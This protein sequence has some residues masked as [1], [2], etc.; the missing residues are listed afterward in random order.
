MPTSF[1]Q[2]LTDRIHEVDSLLC[3]GL[4]PHPHLLPEH[5]PQA[6]RDFCLRLIESTAKA[7]C[8]FKPNSA[9]FEVLGS[10]GMEVLKEVIEAVPNGIPVILDAKRGDIAS[11]SRYYAR[12]AFHMLGADALTVSP[13]LGRDSIDPMIEDPSR[14]AFLLCK[15]SNPGGED[16]QSRVLAGGDPLYLHLARQAVEWNQSDNLGLVVGA[17]DPE[18]LAAVRSV[19]P[20]MWFLAPGVGAQGGNMEQALAGGLRSDGLGMILSLSRGIAQAED[21]GQEA[22]HLRDAINRA[23]PKSK[24]GQFRIWRQAWLIWQMIYCAQDACVSGLID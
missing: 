3:V 9:F 12:M 23:V 17:T 24:A 18:A 22:R 16:I 13:F 14:G 10:D 11:T 5:T 15:T 20:D 4:D 7:V 2:R 1:F 21:P 8:A 19:A 6:V